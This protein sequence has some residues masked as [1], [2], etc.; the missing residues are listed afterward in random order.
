MMPSWRG[1][2]SVA[3]IRAMRRWRELGRTPGAAYNYYP[4]A[5]WRMVPVAY[6][7]GK[8][9]YQDSKCDC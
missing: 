9:D 2:W 5:V 1:D 8:I 7:T 3:A 6:A 4:A